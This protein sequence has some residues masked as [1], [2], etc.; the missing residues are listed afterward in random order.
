MTPLRHYTFNWTPGRRN[1]RRDL[2]FV[3]S[4]VFGATGFL[5]PGGPNILMIL[6][7]TLLFMTALMERSEGDHAQ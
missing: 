1:V 7:A 3:G 6:G 2:S 4:L 5:W